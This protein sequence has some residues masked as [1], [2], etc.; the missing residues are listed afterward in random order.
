MTRY[1][2]IGPMGSGKST[3]ARV[4][5]DRLHCSR[6]DS[7]ELVEQKVG[8]P[9]QQ[10]FV[11]DGEPVFRTAE[12]EIAARLISD[13][14]ATVVS[15]GGGSVLD[16][17]TR[18]DLRAAAARGAVV[19]FLDVPAN[20]ASRRVGLGVGRPLLLGNPRATWVR[21]LA[22]RRP[23]YEGI[24]TVVVDTGSRSPEQVADA[25]LGSAEKP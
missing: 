5:A 24:A 25:I 17:A 22:E 18:E 23:T 14:S 8:K 7:D 12:R 1:L 21:L 3:V 10:I 16:P 13:E 20:E 2:L 9:V 15:L 6:H 4:L 19:A 11:D